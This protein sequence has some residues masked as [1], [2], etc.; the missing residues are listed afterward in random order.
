MSSIT[1]AIGTVCCIEFI[2]PSPK[3]KPPL[4]ALCLEAKLNY[5]QYENSSLLVEYV[6]VVT[7][8]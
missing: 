4:A 3:S 2:F 5:P 7:G 8:V 1:R 6:N